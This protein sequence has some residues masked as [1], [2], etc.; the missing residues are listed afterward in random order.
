MSNLALRTETGIDPYS[1]QSFA[2]AMTLAEKIAESRLFGIGDA[3]KAVVI[4]AC[5]NELGLS[6]MQSLRGIHII[7][8]KPSPSAD[9]L[10]AIV[11]RSGLAEYFREVETTPEQ[12]TWET[13]RRGEPVAL[14]TFSMTDA[15]A[16]KLVKPGSNWEKHPQRMLRARAKAFLARDI[17]TDLLFGLYSSEE[18]REVARETE[19]EMMEAEVVERDEQPSMLSR[20]ESASKEQLPQIRSEILRDFPKGSPAYGTLAEA[21]QA[22]KAVLAGVES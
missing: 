6:P 21:Y 11:M 14:Y 7:E 2:Q 3:A 4:L 16:A 18:M 9:C 13:K 8:G 15:N 17:Y 12:S 20:I 10:V 5:G 19:P 1:P 22:R